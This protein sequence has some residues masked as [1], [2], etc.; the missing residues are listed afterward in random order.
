MLVMEKNKELRDETEWQS[1]K[2]QVQKQQQELQALQG[3]LAEKEEEIERYKA[4]KGYKLLLRCYHL[5]DCLLPENSGRRVFLRLL[6]KLVFEFPKLKKYATWQNLN[7]LR[8][9]LSKGDLRGILQRIQRKLEVEGGKKQEEEIAAALLLALSPQAESQQERLDETTPV[10]IVVPIYNAYE[11]AKKCLE[12][13]YAHTQHP[14]NLYL[15]NDCSTDERIASWLQELKQQEQ[16]PCLQKL[17]ILQNQENL[18]FVKSVNE[19]IKR[20]SQHVVLLNTDTEVAANWLERLLAPLGKEEKIASVTPFSNSATICSFPRVCQDNALPVGMDVDAID[21]LFAAYGPKKAIEIPTGVGFCMLLAR[22]ALD[23]LGLFDAEAYG[24]GYCEEN[25]WCMRTAKAGWKHVLAPNLF[26]YHKHGASFSTMTNKKKEERIAE[27]FK[28]LLERYPD[29]EEQVHRHILLDP[30]RNVRETLH[31]LVRAAQDK[32]KKGILFIN[33]SLGGGTRL[34]QETLMA[35]LMATHR[36][37]SA[38]LEADGKHLQLCEYGKDSAVSFRLPLAQLPGGWLRRLGEMWRLDRLYINQLIEYPVD[39]VI[40][41]IMESGLAYTYF[42]HDYFCVC[43]SYNLLNMANNYCQAQTDQ[44]KCQSCVRQGLLTEPWINMKA[45]DIEIEQWRTSF[46]VFLKQAEHIIAP[47]ETTKRIVQRYYPDADIEVCEHELPVPAWNTYKKEAAASSPLVVAFIGA[48]GENK[49][50]RFVYDLEAAIRREKL[51]LALK[52]IGLTDVHNEAYKS[53]DGIL[54][55]TGRYDNTEISS[56]LAKYGAALVVIPSIWPETFSYTTSEAMNSGYP[57][58]AFNIGAPAER[59][60]RTGSGWVVDEISA[61]AL[62]AEL[63]RLLS[64]RQEL[65][66]KAMKLQ[67]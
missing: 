6:I 35:K 28:I 30:A 24:K 2:K 52:V 3:K 20:T 25:D 19:G 11:Y 26:V 18:G 36:T 51:P 67:K 37:Y 50:S 54:E 10:D 12:T 32:G 22:Q 61:Q 65:L 1:L 5:R 40:P 8:Y 56:L 53:A 66:E 31:S 4:S 41:E 64:S 62:L 16:P 57:V 48:L 47:S 9:Y 39:S 17:I 27:N 45:R 44:D 42:L 7:K 33:N 49:G 14:Y 23:E 15:I 29:Y 38:E 55:V 43:P 46:R 13:V 58:L 21:A 34:Y 59:I 63:K 60:L